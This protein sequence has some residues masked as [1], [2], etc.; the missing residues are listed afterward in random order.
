MLCPGGLSVFGIGN[1]GPGDNLMGWDGPQVLCQV[2]LPPSDKGTL[3]L[4]GNL[5]ELDVVQG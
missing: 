2:E 3:S 4:G 5:M 1:L